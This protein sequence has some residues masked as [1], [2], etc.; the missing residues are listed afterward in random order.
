MTDAP[1]VPTAGPGAALSAPSLPALFQARAAERGSAPALFFKSGGRWVPISWSEYALAVRRLGNAFL[2]WGLLPDNK[3]AIWSVNRPE[4]HIADLAASHCAAVS[5]GLYPSVA[6]AQALY[7]LNQSEA[8]ILVVGNL[9]QARQLAEVKSELHGLEKVVVIEGYD[10]GLG[11]WAMSWSSALSA[12]DAFARSRP[13]LWDATWRAVGPD[14]VYTLVYTS[15]TTGPSKGAIVTHRNFVWTVDRTMVAAPLTGEDRLLSYLALSHIA[16]RVATH[17]RHVRSGCRVY[18]CSSIDHLVEDLREVRPSYFFG[19]PRVYEKVYA[20]IR[21]RMAATTGLRK[22]ILA[23]AMRVGRRASAAKQAGR[24]PGPLLTAQLRL[25]DRLVF[26][27]MRA[28][29]GLD[30]ARGFSVSTAPISPEILRFFDAI[31]IEIDEIYGQTEDTG[32]ATYNPRGRPRFGTAGIAF[33]GT[34]V[35][36]AEDGEILIRGPHVFQ[37]YYKMPEETAAVLSDGWLRTGDVGTFD[38][39]GYLL[40]TDRKKELIKTAGGKYVA[41]AAMEATLRQHPLV[42]QAVVIGD[43]RP[44]VAALLTLNPE[45][46]ATFAR[47]NGLDGSST[48]AMASAPAVRAELQAA[49]DA[50]NANVS[51]PEQIKRWAV[52]SE[53]FRVGDE[54]TPTAKLK[55]K[56][57]AEKYARQIDELYAGTSAAS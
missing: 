1:A 56:A 15:G 14:D 25:A 52:L 27:G 23:W 11:G 30:Q 47:Q 46:L 44:Y 24:R 48:L 20:G 28:R 38:A 10:G 35:K 12:G 37:G 4:W 13:G 31:N 41:P 19:V 42:S 9:A 6:P 8:K 7:Q 22:L 32:P 39:S 50:A 29:L 2:S 18:F 45:A 36:L 55:R 43:R 54:L 3:V 5:A 51:H 53:D 40:I 57:V 16:E 49:V 17:G 21:A 26:H 33:P 34:E